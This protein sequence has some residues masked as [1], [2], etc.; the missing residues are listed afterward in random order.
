[1]TTRSALQLLLL[2]VVAAGLAYVASLALAPTPSV[3]YPGTQPEARPTDGSG[4]AVPEAAEAAGDEEDIPVAAM[5]NEAIDYPP[6]RY[7]FLEA[8]LL[9]GTV[10]EK[11]AAIRELRNLGNEDAVASLSV[12]LSDPDSRIRDD[13]LEALSAIGTDEALG[14]IASRAVDT[15]P[16]SRADAAEALANSDN[17]YAL[18]YL[19]ILLKDED[20]RVRMVAI[21]SLADIREDRAVTLIS[22]ALRDPDPEVRERASEVLDEFSDETL[23]HDQY[24]PQ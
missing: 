5:A 8:V 15:E 2:A 21:E 16:G 22:R 11:K 19:E 14:A 18:N 6:A 13:A 7:E 12:A 4:A 24:P 9:D 17:R 10:G 20:P 23:F 3:R 1:M